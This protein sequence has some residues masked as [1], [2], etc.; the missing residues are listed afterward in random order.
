MSYDFSNKVVAVTGAARGI[1]KQI[2]K[3][4]YDAGACVAVC[5]I[6]RDY[7]DDL[8]T[9]L[10][11]EDRTR[12]FG[13]A[14]DLTKMD[15]LNGFM[16]DVAAKFG[17]IDVLVNNAGVYM[18]VP[19]TDVTEAQWDLT[20]DVNLKSQFFSAQCAAKD[21]ISRKAPGVIV[22]IASI[23]AQSVVANSTAYCVS[24][25]GVQMLTKC[26]A[27][28]WGGYGIRVNA[29]GPGS[30]PTDINKSIYEQ[31]GKL[32]ALK[33]RLP[34]GRQGTTDEIANAVLFLASDEASYVTGH[35]LFVDGGWL[36]S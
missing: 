27:K 7:S 13:K 4:F 3:R 24:K 31:P 5:S 15:E 10:A 8:L 12:I 14:A 11:G 16:Q 29:V 28:D 23:N 22:N 34:L 30:I 2:A 32:E 9:E 20:L 18:V 33:A 19:S 6:V 36:L 17:R 35:T 1:G 25:A 21:M 26:L